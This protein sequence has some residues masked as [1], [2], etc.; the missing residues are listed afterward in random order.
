[1]FNKS[2]SLRYWVFRET[3]IT[4]KSLPVLR[5]VDFARLDNFTWSCIPDIDLARSSLGRNGVRFYENFPAE[6]EYSF[7]AT[8]FIGVIQRIGR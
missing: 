5:R 2:A 6:K 8:T 1:M 4:G 7:L 3:D